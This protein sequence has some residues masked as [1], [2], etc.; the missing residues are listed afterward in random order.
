[1]LEIPDEEL[2]QVRGAK[3]GMVF[4]NATS[5]LNP[6]FSIGYHVAEMLQVHRGMRSRQARQEAEFWLERVGLPGSYGSYPHQLSGGQAQRAAIALALA[7]GPQLLLADEPTSALD[8]TLQS[9]ILDLVRKLAAEQG[10][11]VILITH[12]LGLIANLAER[13]GVMY[14]GQVVEE[15]PVH[16]LFAEPSH[17]YTKQ[18]ISS[19]DLGQRNRAN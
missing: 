3:I 15:V 7:P 4:Q 10:T 14:G 18:L 16:Q 11:A 13:V 2:D 8:V 12:D 6:T 9:Q 19:I 17:S 5:S 1:M